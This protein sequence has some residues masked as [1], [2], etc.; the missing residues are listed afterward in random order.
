MKVNNLNIFAANYD[1]GNENIL[2]HQQ[3]WIWDS[4]KVAQTFSKY[5]IAFFTNLTKIKLKPANK[6]HHDKHLQNKILL[7]MSLVKK[8]CISLAHTPHF[9]ISKTCEFIRK[10]FYGKEMYLDVK[11]FAQTVLKINLDQ[12]RLCQNSFRKL[13]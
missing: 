13:I 8:D 11:N 10:K 4:I 3:A 1:L 7:P 2:R 9:G 5:F 12:L 6:N